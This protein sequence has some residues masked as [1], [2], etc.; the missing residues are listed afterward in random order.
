MLCNTCN[1]ALLRGCNCW[2]VRAMLMQLQVGGG[3]RGQLA[4]LLYSMG[5]AHMQCV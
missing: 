4:V 5:A 2:M 1:T 3:R